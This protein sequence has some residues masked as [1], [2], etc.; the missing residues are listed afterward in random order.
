MCIAT[1]C[2]NLKITFILWKMLF[3]FIY[4]CFIFVIQIICIYYSVIVLALPSSTSETRTAVPFTTC[5]A[6]S[7]YTHILH[8][9]SIKIRPSQES[10]NSNFFAHDFIYSS[11]NSNFLIVWGLALLSHALF[12]ARHRITPQPIS[13]SSVG[14]SSTISPISHSRFQFLY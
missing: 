7:I 6:S 8:I 9:Q 12:L 13:F 14:I 5:P 11:I 2:D 1:R 4:P 10:V 3:Q